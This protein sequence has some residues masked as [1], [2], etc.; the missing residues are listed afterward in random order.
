MKKMHV[1]AFSALLVP[2]IVLANELPDIKAGL[3]EIETTL[4][5][6]SE[7]KSMQCMDKNTTR[8]IMAA[9]TKMLGNK[10]SDV[11]TKKQ[12]SEYVSKLECDLGGS[13]MKSN[14]VLRGDFKT[15][16]TVTADTTFNPP[17]MGQSKSNSL[18]TAKYL[19]DCK[20]GMVPGDTILPDGTKVNLTKSM[21]NMPDLSELSSMQKAL[22]SGNVEELMQKMQNLQEMQKQM[23]GGNN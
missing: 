9:S 7:G 6:A 23:Q 4:D 16:F 11:Q 8:D 3:W 5:G 17:F 15:S 10:C 20:E 1:L 19:G 12:G 18:S 21:E 2:S 22:E 14:S 13:K